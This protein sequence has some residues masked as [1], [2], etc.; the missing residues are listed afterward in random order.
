MS[1]TIKQSDVEDPEADHE[2]PALGGHGSMLARAV[3][4]G[5]SL[6]AYF[7]FLTVCLDRHVGGR[8][9]H[10]LAVVGAA[11]HVDFGSVLHRELLVGSWAARSCPS[12]ARR[13]TSRSVRFL[14]NI[15]AQVG[16]VI[17]TSSSSSRAA[18]C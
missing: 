14:A 3:A 8:V 5:K 18:A 15:G 6:A 16:T 11:E 13:A 2:D 4:G 10:P 12:R 7:R 1:H 17:A 9:E